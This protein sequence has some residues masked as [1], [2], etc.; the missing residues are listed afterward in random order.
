MN[1]ILK[2]LKM[3]FKKVS[4]S[5]EPPLEIIDITKTLP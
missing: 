5:K 2:I 4:Q 3:I 1:K